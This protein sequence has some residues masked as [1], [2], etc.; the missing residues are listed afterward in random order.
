VESERHRIGDL[1]G[2]LVAR[3]T[4]KYLACE[5]QDDGANSLNEEFFRLEIPEES[6]MFGTNGGLS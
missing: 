5:Q 3:R 6:P 2:A 4:Q 1:A